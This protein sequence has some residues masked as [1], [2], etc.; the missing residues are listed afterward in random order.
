MSTAWDNARRHARALETA[1]GTKLSTYSRL[2]ADI[3][4]SAGGSREREDR[5]ELDEGEGGYKLLEQAIDDLMT[6][7]N[8]PSQPPSASMQHAAQ[9]HRDN[10]DDYRRDFLRTRNNVEAAVARSNLLG[11]VRKDINDYKSASPSQ[12]DAL[13]ADRGRIDSSHRMIDDTLNQAYATRE[14]FAQQRTFLARID[15]RLGGVLSQ[16][17]GIN[18]LISMI[19][20][21]RRRDSIIVACVVAFCVLLLLGYMFGF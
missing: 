4:R 8:S 21:R 10:L 3:S 7:I 18:S 9:R 19:H 16:I 2:A 11:S 5:E 13:L 20:S 6:L 15:S 1:L 12:T 14:D 17:P